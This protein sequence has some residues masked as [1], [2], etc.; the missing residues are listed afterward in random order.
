MYQE[1]LAQAPAI[2]EEAGDAAREIGLAEVSAPLPATGDAARED[3]ATRR[4]PEKALDRIREV[5]KD[6]YGDDY[7]CC[8]VTSPSLGLWLACQSGFAVEPPGP[9]RTSAPRLR[10]RCIVP[11]QKESAL[12]GG[13]SPLPPKY[14]HIPDRARQDRAGAGAVTAGQ[15]SFDAVIVPLQSAMYVHHGASASPVS[16]LAGANYQASLEAIAAAAEV[17]GPFLCGF[18]SQGPSTP[19]CGFGPTDEEGVHTLARGLTELAAEFDVPCVTGETFAL[20]FLGG[21]ALGG[22]GRGRG[23]SIAVYGHPAMG[24]MGLIAGTEDLVTPL[25]KEVA[26]AT[27]AAAEAS[28]AQDSGRRGP[29]VNLAGLPLL[30]N[31]LKDLATDPARYTRVVDR[32]YDIVTPELERLGSRFKQD[33]R[34]RK[35]YGSLA[36]EVNYE[37]TW[38]SGQGFPIFTVEDSRAGTNLLEAGISAMGITSVSVLEASLTVH[39]PNPGPAGIALDEERAR[40]EMRGLVR[41]MEIVSKRSGYLT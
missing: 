23:T 11:R 24:G 38:R 35:D 30:L 8:P 17:H 18:F 41:L 26:Y 37:D 28:T 39:V 5:V 9:G 19:G 1:L 15:D 16:M 29:A 22:T 33:L 13:L 7:D 20:P 25:L 12:P 14:R 36:V 4:S 27:V 10:P 34:V 21:T 6:R 2:L 32:L 40:L 31:L 3:T